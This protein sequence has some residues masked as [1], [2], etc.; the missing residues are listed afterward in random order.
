MKAQ[1]VADFIVQHR[2]DKQLDL[3]V[4]YVTFTPWKLHFDGSACS[5]GCDVGI[6]IVSPSGAIFECTNNQIEYEALLFG[7]Q[8]LHDT[9]VKH[10]E[11]YGDSF[12]VVQQVSKVCQ[13]LNGS[14]IAYLDKCLDIISCMDEF[15]IYHVPREENPKANAL[16]Q[17]ASG[18]NVQKII[19]QERKPMFGEAEGYCLEDPVQPSSQDSQ[20]RY[21][22][23][24]APSGRSNRPSGGN[25]TSATISSKIVEDELGD[26]RKPLVKYLQDPK[27]MSDKK[28]Q[29]WVLKCLGPDQA[30]LAMAEVHEGICGAHQSTP[31]MKWL[32]RRACFYWPTMIADCF[33]YYKGCEECQKHGDIQLVPSILLHPTIKPWP[34]RGWGLDFIGKIHPPSIKGHCFVI[35]ATDYFTKWTEAIPLKNMT[36]KEVIGFITEQ[37]IHRFGIPRTLTTNQGTSFVAKEV[38]DFVN[39]YGIKLLNSSSRV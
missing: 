2:I 12:L 14:L 34:F 28:V 27:S 21:P 20:T 37:I 36:H 6:I 24:T 3:D 9:G 17:Q 10:V 18:Y 38:R 8:I 4:G 19:F 30:R 26:W 31:K 25:P 7:L 29:R 33:R 32:L 13:C 15:V 39:S 16:A 22:G 5:S 1:I 11:A 23:Q 35:V